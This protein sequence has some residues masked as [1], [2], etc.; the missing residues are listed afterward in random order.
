MKKKKN[1][2]F[3]ALPKLLPPHPPNSGNLVLFFG[4]KTG[5]DRKNAD[6][7]NDGCNDSYVGNLMIMMTKMT[8]RTYKYKEFWVKNYQF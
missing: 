5:Q 4:R 3:R 7:D 8:K 6:D 1:V 2:F